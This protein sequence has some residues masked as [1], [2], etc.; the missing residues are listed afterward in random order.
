M[1]YMG[2]EVGDIF[3]KI[4]SNKEINEKLKGGIK[5]ELGDIEIYLGMSR[6]VNGNSKMDFMKRDLLQL[7]NN[8]YPYKTYLPI[9]KLS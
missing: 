9:Q 8:L 1:G 2:D 6:K 7:T 4:E 5:K 3:A